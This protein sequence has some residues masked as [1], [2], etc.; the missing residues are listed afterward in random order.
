MPDPACAICRGSGWKVEERN[1]ISGAA[2]C[3]C[4]IVDT[5][6]QAWQYSGIP[7]LYQNSALDNFDAQGNNELMKVMLLVREYARQYPVV[8]KPGLLLIGDPGTGK[9]HLAVS[10]LRILIQRGFGGLFYDYQH[11]LQK[12]RSSYDAASG[13]GDREAYSNAMEAEILL[14]DDLGAHRITDWVEDTV[15]SL[16]TYRCNHKRP[17]IAT[18][19][20]PDLDMQPTDRRER[21]TGGTDYKRSLIDQIGMRAR[22][23]LFE[24]CRVIRMPSQVED[25]RLRKARIH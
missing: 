9:T 6:K 11:L 8:D 24:M 5:Q 7:A 19:N 10:A 21:P 25:Y 13:S 18:T 3:E 20:L 16:I 14:L 2:R 15:T 23:R 4:T 17:I 22:S 12:I 1:G